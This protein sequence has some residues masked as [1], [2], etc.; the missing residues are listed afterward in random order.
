MIKITGLGLLLMSMMLHYDATAQSSVQEIRNIN[1]NTK[2][3]VCDI[4]GK[5]VIDD[6]SKYQISF[7]KVG[8][9]YV[10]IEG[11][12]HGV[13]NYS[14]IIDKDSIYTNGTAANWQPY[15]CK[16]KLLNKNMLEIAFYQYFT[17]D[18]YRVIFSR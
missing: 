2:I 11:I 12:K 13:G 7:S 18:A 8:N 9:F 16:L 6:S 4:L 17:T 10:Q 5:W 1:K 14:F 3:A 15:D